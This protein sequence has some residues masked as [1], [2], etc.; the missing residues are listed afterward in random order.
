MGAKILVVEDEPAIRLAV[1]DALR[2]EGFL[3]LEAEDGSEGY[4]RTGADRPDLVILD[5]MLPGTDGLDVLVRL[6]R[7]GN[8]VPVIILTAKGRE[9]DRV[10]GLHAGADDYVPKPFGVKE[11]VARVRALLRRAGWAE[12]PPRR[13]V[14]GDLRIDLDRREYEIA[15][16]PPRPLTRLEADVLAYLAAHA[17]RIV[18]REELLVR[19]WGYPRDVETRTVENLI[20]SLRRKLEDDPAAP[21]VLLTLRGAGFSLGSGVRCEGLST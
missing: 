19:V 3:V 20:S 12:R 11:L 14:A 9:T 15:D 1:T 16:A 6:R 8:R 5:L 17:G 7:E 4:R 10:Q 2:D 18:P 21:G 13:L